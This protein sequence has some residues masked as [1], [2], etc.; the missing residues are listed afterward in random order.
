MYAHKGEGMLPGN[1]D[2]PVSLACGLRKGMMKEGSRAGALF[3][4]KVRAGSSRVFALA[5]RP[6]HRVLCE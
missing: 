1:K 3:E 6:L 2:V 5:H 4:P